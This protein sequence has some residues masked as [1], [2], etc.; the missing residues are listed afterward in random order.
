MLFHTTTQFDEWFEDWSTRVGNDYLNGQLLA[1][2]D[3]MRDRHPYWG[4][5]PA[6]T[7][8]RMGGNV[9]QWA[10]LILVYFPQADLPRVLCV[11]TFESGGNPNAYN[12]N[13][14][15][16]G[17]M[18]ILSSWA[19]DFG[20]VPGDLFNPSVNLAVARQLRNE[21]WSHWNPVKDGRC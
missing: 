11:M 19:D 10:D 3:N 2:F 12:S 18:Q 7:S 20:Y 21:T 16:S 14:G 6:V 13:S 15:A 8:R 5:P 9:T 17:L 4:N 1:E